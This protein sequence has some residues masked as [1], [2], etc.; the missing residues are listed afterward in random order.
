MKVGNEL[1]EESPQAIHNQ[2][3]QTLDGLARKPYTSEKLLL[4]AIDRIGLK[5]EILG[6]GVRRICYVL[7]PHN[8]TEPLGTYYP[9][10]E[11]RVKS[12]NTRG[13][14]VTGAGLWW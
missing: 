12:V 9:C 7:A 10:F 3:R 13:H 11:M 14:V 4:E 5:A 8:A 2:L 1:L 6:N